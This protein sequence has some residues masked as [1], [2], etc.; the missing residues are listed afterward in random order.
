MRRP[1]SLATLLI[2]CL[3]TIAAAQTKR[4]PF[5]EPPHSV[6]TRSFDVRHLR[7]DLTFDWDRRELRGRAT[8]WLKPFARTRTV[9]LDAVDLGVERVSLESDGPQTTSKD[10]RFEQRPRSVAIT[11]DREYGPGEEVAVAIDYRVVKPKAGAHFVVPD[12]REPEKRKIVWTQSQPD[13]ARRWFPCFDSP[14]ERITSETAVTVPR[15]FFVLSNGILRGKRD[16][17]DGTTTWHWVQ[18]QVHSAYLMSVVAGEFDS[19]EQNWDGIPVISYVPPGRLGEAERSFGKTPAMMRLFSEQIGY[20][21]PWPKY[22]QICCEDYGGGME[23]TSAT[24]LTLRT[25]HDERAHLDVSSDN[26]VAHELAHQWWGDLLTCKDWA[27]LWLNESFATYFATLWTEH[28]QGWD[29]AAWARYGEAESYFTEDEKRYRRPI[30]SYRY[31]DSNQMFDRHSY[32]KGGR[33]LHMLRFVLG[34]ELFWKSLKQYITTH[35][36]GVVETADLRVA[37]EEASGQGLNWFFDEWLYRGG[38]PEFEVSYAWDETARQLRLTV[39]QTQ[40]LDDL[41]PLFHMPVEVDLVTKAQT[42]RQRIEV[43]KAEE[44]FT[45]SLP[46]RPRRVVFDPRDWILKKLK[47]EKSKQ[48]LLDQL[49]HDPHTIPRIQA[50]DGL[51]DLRS[52]DDALEALIQAAEKDAFWAVRQRAAEALGEASGDK[53]RACL[54]RVASNDPKSA[55]R[56]AAV[57]SLGAFAHDE[58]QR[59]LRQIVATDPS[60]YTVAEALRTLVKVDRTGAVNDLMAALDVPS[61]SDVILAAACDGLA[62]LRP[63]MAKAKLLSLLQPPAKPTRRMA[64]VKALSRLAREDSSLISTLARELD[65]TRSFVQQSVAESLGETGDPAAVALLEQAR[66]K[67]DGPGAM[68]SIDEALDKLRKTTDVE[69]LRREVETLHNENRQFEDRLKKLEAAERKGAD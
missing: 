59:T 24:T 25:L 50:V 26:L 56:R 33:V 1:I 31:R 47:F 57:K 39:K 17:S 14:G 16:N 46:E 19:Y 61:H 12:D 41:T 22:A 69:R 68:R 20:R 62:E 54:L 10:L 48:E 63:E 49:A 40:K 42:E 60:Y 35:A 30:V 38:H 65:D 43:S 55:V 7:L 37:I 5:V 36:H 18:D 34:D 27:E 58:T 4:G 53:A 45:F 51:K 21:Y 64:A 66:A 23:H 13:D 44:T 28:D 67:A 11:L 15:G 32:P 6:R 52:Q 2:V 29:E 3:G 8:H 9:E